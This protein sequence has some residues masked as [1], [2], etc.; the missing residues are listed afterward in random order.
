MKV[1]IGRSSR[2]CTTAVFMVLWT[3]Q[4]ILAT[5][6]DHEGVVTGNTFNTEP[7]YSNTLNE[8]IWKSKRVPEEY[9]KES[10]HGVFHKEASKS[11]STAKQFQ[12]KTRSING[13]EIRNFYKA[14]LAKNIRW[15][16]DN[17]NKIISNHFS[18]D[19]I[20]QSYEMINNFD[21]FMEL[22]EMLDYDKQL[23]IYSV[24]QDLL[25]EENE[26]YGDICHLGILWFKMYDL[27]YVNG[28]SSKA[29][30]FDQEY[31]NGNAVNRERYIKTNG[32]KY[33]FLWWKDFSIIPS[34][35]TTNLYNRLQLL[36][37][38]NGHNAV[39]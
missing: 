31:R 16:A 38:K 21:C 19:F 26:S 28:N 4:L 13:L 3:S 18:V 33:L 12:R 20:K 23:Q 17:F 24:L 36:S 29:F 25:L 7:E 35:I 30:K 14:M 6:A 34:M 9:I 39:R 15:A 32:G 22:A 8:E 1:N 11:R 2:L 10:N 5:S 37:E 27:R